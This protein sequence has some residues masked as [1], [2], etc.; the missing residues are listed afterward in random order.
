M[1]KFLQENVVD[2]NRSRLTVKVGDEEVFQPYEVRIRAF[3]SVGPGPLSEV[4]T[5]YSA[6]QGDGFDGIQ[7]I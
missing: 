1:L 6:E 3:N 5:V 7:P 4:T 2:G